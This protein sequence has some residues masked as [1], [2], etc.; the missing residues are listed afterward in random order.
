M[1][2]CAAKHVAAMPLVCLVCEWQAFAC[3]PLVRGVMGAV[4]QRRWP[5]LTNAIDCMCVVP[6]SLRLDDCLLAC[7]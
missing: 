7:F 5:R 2:D 6:F 3:T 4:L 1:V